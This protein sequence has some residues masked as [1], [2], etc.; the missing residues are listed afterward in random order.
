MEIPK[1]NKRKGAFTTIPVSS[2]NPDIL[3]IPPLPNPVYTEQ[4]ENFMPLGLLALTAALKQHNFLSDIYRPSIRI[5]SKKD[6]L[7]VAR[8]ILSRKPR[9]VG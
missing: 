2:N 8:D 6:I 1:Q 9:S 5:Y 3:L 7:N 4:T